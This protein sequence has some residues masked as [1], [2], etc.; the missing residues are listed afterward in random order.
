[1]IVCLNIM[2]VMR[3]YKKTINENNSLVW[4]HCKLSAIFV[5]VHNFL[6]VK[7]RLKLL[8]YSVCVCLVYHLSVI[9]SSSEFLYFY[10]KWNLNFI[11][12][13][14][15]IFYQKSHSILLLIYIVKRHSGN[16]A[17]DI[18]FISLIMEHIL[19]TLCQR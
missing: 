19:R 3:F 5:N 11:Q 9:F 12:K 2:K 8:I 1:M 13:T 4:E 6:C 10:K 17:Q 14:R 18:S 16:I 15:I 7:S